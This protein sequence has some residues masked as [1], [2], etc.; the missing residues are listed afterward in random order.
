MRKKKLALNTITGLAVQVVTIVCGLI[1]PRLILNCYGSD[2][3][4]LLNSITQFISIISFLDFGVGA[5][6][7]SSLYGPLATNDVRR[8]SEIYV[9][10][11]K[12]FSRLGKILMIYIIVL[13]LCY[14]LFIDDKFNVLFTSSLIFVISISSFAQYFFGMANSLFIAA[15]QRAYIPNLLQVL[16]VVLNTLFCVFLIKF[17]ATIHIVKLVT[18]LVYLIRPIVLDVYI[19]KN[20]SINRKISCATDSI[21]QKWNGLAQHV[22]SVVLESTDTVVLTVFGT[23]ADVSIYSVYYLVIS[24]I[25]QLFMSVT[26]GIQALI[27]ELYAKKEF[28]TLINTFE[29]TEWW[30]HTTATLIYGCTATLIVSFVEVY[31]KGI[32]DAN[33]DRPLFAY[34]IVLAYMLYTYRLPYHIAIK[35]AVH[36]KQTQICYIIAT[37]LNISISIIFV[38]KFGLV[39]VAIGTLSAMVYQ[40]I[41]MANYNYKHI[42]KSNMSSFKKQ[43]FVDLI[44]FLI[45]LLCSSFIKLHEISY[46]NWFYI[47]IESTIIW[48]VIIFVINYIFYPLK[49]KKV[50]TSIK[51]F[52]K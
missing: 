46:I 16:T 6:F 30:I 45:G 20:Y 9:T 26:I 48:L 5:V 11:K 1:L 52:G 29:W 32:T 4:G 17:G 8:I 50:I 38:S 43:I 37:I 36:Y 41:W 19:R 23:L 35:A 51:S 13:M 10:G 47:A 2:V 39:G 42:I 21:K 24:G 12:F 49:I 18:S 3:N 44:T 33:Y 40:T 31:T 27:G 7:Q 28:T 34:L 25:K 14:P 15:D 22:S